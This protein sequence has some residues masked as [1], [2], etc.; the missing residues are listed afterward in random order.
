MVCHKILN[1]LKP[2]FEM[3]DLV[4]E[5]RNKRRQAVQNNIVGFKLFNGHYS[6]FFQQYIF[7]YRCVIEILIAEHGLRKTDEVAKFIEDYDHVVARKA[8]TKKKSIIESPGDAKS[9]DRPEAKS[10]GN[11]KSNSKLEVKSVGNEKSSNKLDV[12]DKVVLK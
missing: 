5:L 6:T 2:R 8:T 4:K 1:E 7:I 10:A 9:N 11:A 3:V 12:S